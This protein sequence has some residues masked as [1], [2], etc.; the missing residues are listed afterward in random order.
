MEI[1]TKSIN[2]K[3]LLSLKPSKN[4]EIAFSL[5]PNE[6]ISKYELKTP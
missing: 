2:I 3:N 6:V 1:R 4:V 5:N